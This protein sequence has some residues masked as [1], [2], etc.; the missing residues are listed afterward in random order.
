M[1]RSG[2]LK[3]R[4]GLTH[5]T[6]MRKVSRQHA[7]SQRELDALKPALIERSHGLCEAQF[8]WLCSGVG[9]QPHHMLKRSHARHRHRLDEILWTCGFCN[10]DV[11]VRPD[12]AYAA[13]L[14]IKSWERGKVGVGA[15]RRRREAHLERVR[16]AA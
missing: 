9:S 8:S 5:R 3:R 4:T 15:A 2:P 12:E 13:G 11:E 10:V 7:K 16:T 1:K 6:A 14:T